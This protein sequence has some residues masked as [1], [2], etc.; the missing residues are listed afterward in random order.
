MPT[1]HLANVVDDHEMA[2][3]HVIRGEEWLP[4]APLHVLLY[5]AFGW[6]RPT[7]AHL[8]LILKPSGPGKLSKRD[9]D[10]F[11][12]PVFPLEW[13]DPKNG[14]LSR[15]FREDGYLPSAFLNMLL[16]LGWN[17]GD[18]RELFTLE[19]MTACF[20]IDRVQK[21]GARF[22]PDKAKWFNEQYLRALTPEALAAAVAPWTQGRGL[23]PEQ[24]LGACALMA[25]RSPSRPAWRRLPLCSPATYDEKPSAKIRRALPRHRDRSACTLCRT[26]RI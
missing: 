26:G 18:E 14:E 3:S 21:A 24:V 16:M 23:T 25:E 17:P 8:P 11:G 19:E 1:Y 7:F 4:S 22:S 6:D 12:F 9:G 15:G 5:E 10:K 13:S 2:I 20:G